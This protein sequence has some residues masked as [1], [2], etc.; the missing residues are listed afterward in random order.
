MTFVI[1]FSG[2]E[3]HND[4]TL[5]ASMLKPLT[6]YPRMTNVTAI[7]ARRVSAIAG[8]PSSKMKRN[9]AENSVSPCISGIVHKTWRFALSNVVYC[10]THS[11]P[12]TSHVAFDVSF[13][14]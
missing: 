5:I 12:G 4:E 13:R 11:D 6:L 2:F 8:M 1:D 3:Y 9:R 14:C 7:G 10:A